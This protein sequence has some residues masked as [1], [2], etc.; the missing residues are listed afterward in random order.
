MVDPVDDPANAE[1]EVGLPSTGV[2]VKLAPPSIALVY[3]MVIAPVD[4]LI[5]TL[6]TFFVPE[7]GVQPEA[8]A[9]PFA[10]FS[11]TA[12][13]A[14]AAIESPSVTFARTV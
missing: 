12:V 3:V 13:L 5:A 7:G 4:A 1:P 10:A 9:A 8:K 6:E 2:R 11:E 14:D